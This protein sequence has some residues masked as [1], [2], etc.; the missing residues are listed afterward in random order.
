[1]YKHNDQSKAISLNGLQLVREKYNMKKMVRRYMENYGV[2]Q[3]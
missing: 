1:V 2:K 3:Q